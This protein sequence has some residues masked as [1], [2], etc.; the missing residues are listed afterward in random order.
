MGEEERERVMG[1]GRV[2]RKEGRRERGW[3]L[4]E[5]REGGDCE[6]WA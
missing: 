3:R 4:E 1:G 2:S 5:E 6:H